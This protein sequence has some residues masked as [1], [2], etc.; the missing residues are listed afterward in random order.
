MDRAIYASMAEVDT[1]HWWY[2]ARR[3]VLAALVAR[4]VALPPDARVLEVGCGTGHNL[5]M[6]GG[7]GRVDAVELDDFARE[8][9]TRRLGRPVSPGA[10]P[11]LPGIARDAYDMVALLDVLEHVE[12][13]VAALRAIAARMK[14]GATLLLTVPQHMWM[15][16]GHDVANHHF[17]RYTKRTLRAAADAAGMRI[18]LLQSF[19]SLLFPLAVAARAAANAR[20]QEGKQ[21]ALPSAPVNRVLTEIFAFERHLVGRMPMLPGLSLVALLSAR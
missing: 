10:L 1:T 13:D 9:A 11:E 3:D 2:V 19:N 16:S 21:D 20:G 12:D 7:F 17:R 4:K 6:L 8:L 15:W 5:A 18:T 14:P